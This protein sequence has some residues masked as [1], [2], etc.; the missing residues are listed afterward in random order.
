MSAANALTANIGVADLISAAVVGANGSNAVAIPSLPILGGTVS[1]VAR[2]ISPPQ[3]GVGGVGATATTA[4]LRLFVTVNSSAGTLGGLLNG[5]GTQLNLP[6]VLEAAQSTATVTALQCGA[7]LPRL[8]K[9][10]PG[11]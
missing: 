8:S 6:L 9:S 2:V 5:L 11:W 3:V 10:I 1:V 7:T 4:Q